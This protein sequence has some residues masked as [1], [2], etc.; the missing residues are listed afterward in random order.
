MREGFLE[1][2]NDKQYKDITNDILDHLAMQTI[3]TNE[4]IISKEVVMIFNG[5]FVFFCAQ[6]TALREG[7][8]KKGKGGVMSMAKSL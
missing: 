3:H 7:K 6:K 1:Q 5:T 8:K 2:E 4:N